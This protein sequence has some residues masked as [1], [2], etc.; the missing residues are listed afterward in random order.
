MFQTCFPSLPSYLR[1]R[2]HLLNLDHGFYTTYPLSVAYIVCVSTLH[3]LMSL[4]ISF[5]FVLYMVCLTY[6]SPFRSD[7][8]FISI[9]HILCLCS[10]YFFVSIQHVLCVTHTSSC[11]I[12]F[13][14]YIFSVSVL[15][16]S[17]S[18]SYISSV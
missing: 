7:M 4:S 9:L 13:V 11:N 10:T 2:T 6:L 1:L 18:L 15:D 14:T 16:I 17:L 5:L 12:S 3:I 8:F